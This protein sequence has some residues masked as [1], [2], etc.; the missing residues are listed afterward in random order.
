MTIFLSIVFLV[1]LISWVLYQKHQFKE[2]DLYEIKPQEAYE[3]NKKW[4]FWKGI[5]H[6]SVYVLVW[7]LYGFLPMVFFATAFWF[8]FDILCN[9]IVLK[10]PAFYVGKTAQTDL[11]IR[12]VSELIKIKPEYASAL[13]KVLIL[14][15]L[16]ILK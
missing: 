10:R 5:N 7:S 11:F 2:R 1:H 15:I 6:L 8:G 3:Q 16:I 4:H 12:K 13:I 14:L 9:V